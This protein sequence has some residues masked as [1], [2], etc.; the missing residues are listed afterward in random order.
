MAPQE[1]DGLGVGGKE[2]HTKA[3]S[4]QAL[5]APAGKAASVVCKM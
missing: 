2:T 4:C 5:L 3:L 1:T